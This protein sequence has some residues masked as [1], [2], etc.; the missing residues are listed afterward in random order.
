M[1]RATANCATTNADIHNWLTGI[2]GIQLL[3]IAGMWVVVK[4]PINTTLDTT[5]LIVK[6]ELNLKQLLTQVA[7][8]M[9]SQL[10]IEYILLTTQLRV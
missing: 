6:D 8:Q 3:A 2:D 1:L 9:N 10:N 7:L 5:Q 4:L